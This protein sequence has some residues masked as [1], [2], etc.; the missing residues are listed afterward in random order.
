MGKRKKRAWFLIAME[1][2]LNKYTVLT[3]I[4][5]HVLTGC[6]IGPTGVLEKSI[7][8]FDKEEGIVTISGK[9]PKEFTNVI[10][11]NKFATEDKPCLRKNILTT[12][13]YE[14]YHEVRYNIKPTVDN[15]GNYK[16]TLPTKI[17]SSICDWEHISIDVIG[18]HY[19]SPKQKISSE[20]PI[21][22]LEIV[23]ITDSSD[24]KYNIPL[25]LNH[26]IQCR[27]Y[28]SI[29]AAWDEAFIDCPYYNKDLDID[30]DRGYVIL[31]HEKYLKNKLHYKID[32]SLEQKIIKLDKVKERKEHG[33]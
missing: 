9:M 24:P 17:N 31:T 28:K 23:F 25:K 32:I 30:N 10:F 4:T 18:Y 2:K 33:F 12:G 29:R 13:K 6:S 3:L 8:T 16:V 5:I 20:S 26:K 11:K 7:R 15:K 21:K 27:K 22:I 1:Y 19:D 14:S